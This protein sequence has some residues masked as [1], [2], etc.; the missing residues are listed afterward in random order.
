MNTIK[1]AWCTLPPTA[2]D[3]SAQAATD[4]NSATS[5]AFT[6][7]LKRQQEKNGLAAYA[8]TRSA[9]TPPST[10]QAVPEALSV[11][12]ATPDASMATSGAPATSEVTAESAAPERTGPERPAARPSDLKDAFSQEEF[13]SWLAKVSE[14]KS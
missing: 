9:T 2:A 14:P 1:T 11:L 4:A 13:E 8:A 3:I 7:Y 12:G 5:A 10:P 6:A